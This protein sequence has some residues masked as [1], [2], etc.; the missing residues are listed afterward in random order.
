M[1]KD[2]AADGPVRVLI[3]NDHLGYGDALHG[4]GR[5]LLNITTR[6]DPA[7]V[8][9]VPVILR[10]EPRLSQFF[11]ERGVAIR[12]LGRHKQDP[13]ALTDLVRIVREERIEVIHVQAL[14]ADTIGRIA[15][16]L[17]GV[18]TILHGRD[19]IADR[20]LPLYV[21]D[22]VLGPR[23]RHALAVSETVRRYLHNERFIPESSIQVF[24]HGVDLSVFAGDRPGD[25]EAVRAEL[26]VPG[27]APVAGTTIRLHPSKGHSYLLQGVKHVLETFPDFRLLIANEGPE[28]DRLKEEAR[29]LGIAERVVFTGSR[30]DVRAFLSALDVF[31]MPSLSEGFPNSML[32]AMAMGRPVVATHVDG[33]GEML[34]DDENALVVPPADGEAMG[35]ALRRLLGDDGLRR[36]LSA[37]SLAFAQELSIERTTERLTDLYT[38]IARG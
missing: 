9:A 27:D 21:L 12:C 28:A 34:T 19:R 3:G 30:S 37:A 8:Q 13:R 25:R 23:T 17:T 18:P 6:F 14:K 7:R 2:T 11:Q 16:H 24:Y 10:P 35:Q 1:S 32:E 26:G 29:T 4:V 20:P 36:R 22:R 33:M 5:Y 38:R 15:G 31:V